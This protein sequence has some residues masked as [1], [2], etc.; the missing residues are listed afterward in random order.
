MAE[1]SWQDYYDLGKVTLQT[2]RPKFVVIEGD[3]TDAIIAGVASCATA[4]TAQSAR[5]FRTTFLDGADDQDLTDRAHDRG[6]DRDQGAKAIG[7]VTLTRPGVGA[8]AGTITAGTRV[9]TD[10]DSTGQFQIYTLDNDV[11]YGALDL[12]ETQT[13]TCSRVGK[14][15]NVGIGSDGITRFIDPIFDDTIVPSN[16]ERIAGGTEVESDEDLRD[17]VRGFFLTQARGTLD[18]LVY[19]AKQVD[20]VTRVS[21][22]V[23]SAGVITV[24]VADADGNSNTAMVDAVTAELEH[25]RDAAD[26]VYVTGGVIVLQT[27]SVQISVRTGT[28][29]AALLDR[30]RQ[31]IISAIGRLNPGETLSPDLISTAVRDVDRTNIV[32]ANVLDPLVSI[33]PGVNELIRTNG[34][35]ITL[36]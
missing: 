2:R 36:S 11:V 19:G 28:S 34:G 24:Y 4:I 9:A 35:L 12:T 14:A 6:V 1:L 16:A 23:D 26:V 15:G 8:G 10:P 29:L 7:T 31:S 20:G 27:V 22:S 13:I 18:A 32:R 33:V 25:W 21:I 30:V 3:G 17:R 5:N